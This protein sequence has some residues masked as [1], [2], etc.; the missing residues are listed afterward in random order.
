MNKRSA[1]RQTP[2]NRT[3]FTPIPVQEPPKWETPPFCKIFDWTTMREGPPSPVKTPPEVPLMQ[4]DCFK[5][6]TVEKT[7]QLTAF[8]NENTPP[9]D[10]LPELPLLY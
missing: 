8:Q 2:A 10:E 6:D 5:K 7:C 1:K 4:I 3:P 9:F